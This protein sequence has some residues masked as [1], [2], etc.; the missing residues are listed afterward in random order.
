MRLSGLVF[1]LVLCGCVPTPPWYSVP[2]QHA[3]AGTEE[4]VS[5]G[6]FVLATDPGADSHYLRDVRALEGKWRW[7]LAEPEFR[8]LLKSV[9]N[10]VF[11]MDLAINDVTF[12]DTGPVRMMIRINGQ[13]LDQPVF[14]NPGDYQYEKAVP[15]GTLKENAENH[16]SVRVLNPWK[17]S[18]PGVQLGFLLLGIGFL[19]R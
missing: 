17:A 16:V 4:I 6:E 13:L 18:E 12:R 14:D 8:F 15:P 5:I 2:P 11:R 10:R 1:A 19:S 3:P 9:R 7:T